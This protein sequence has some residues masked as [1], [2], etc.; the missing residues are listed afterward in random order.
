MSARPV[1]LP[2]RIDD[3]GLGR[4]QQLEDADDQGGL[5]YAIPFK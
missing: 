4:R 3:C 5:M 2:G 1:L